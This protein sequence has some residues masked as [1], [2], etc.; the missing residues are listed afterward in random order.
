MSNLLLSTSFTAEAAIAPYRIVKHGAADRNVVQ[1]AAAAD[2]SIGVTME[3]PAAIGERCDVMRV[4]IALVEA[5]AAFTRGAL[6]TADAVGRGV[7]SAPAA[8]V[9]NRV[10]GIAD[11]AATAAG[12]IVRVFISPCSLQG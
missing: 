2:P 1:A 3:L 11:E 7:A 5:G 9:N 6:I 10:I 8:G 4:G 12:D